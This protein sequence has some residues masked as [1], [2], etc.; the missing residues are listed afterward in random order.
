[1]ENSI[2]QGLYDLFNAYVDILIRSIPNEANAIERGNPTT[3]FA[4]TPRQQLSLLANASTLVLHLFSSVTGS[5]SKGI[6]CAVDET[7]TEQAES[8]QQKG[9]DCWILSIQ[10]AA[11]RLRAYFC[12]QF[13]LKVMSLQDE[14]ILS[15]ETNKNRHSESHSLHPPLPSMAFQVLFLQLRQ[16]EKLAREVFVGRDWEVKDLLREL[17]ESVFFWLSNN[18]FWTIDG[19][20]SVAE[21]SNGFEKFLLDM[22]FIVEIARFG[23]YFSENLMDASLGL[24]ERMEMEFLAAGLNPHSDILYDGWAAKA[25]KAAIDK[26]LQ[27][28][29][30][31]L[32]PVEGPVVTL[33]EYFDEQQH[34]DAVDFVEQ[35]GGRYL[36]GPLGFD[37]KTANGDEA[38]ISKLWETDKV[39]ITTME[40]P[41]GVIGE[42]DC[43]DTAESLS[44][45]SVCFDDPRATNSA[46]AMT[47]IVQGMEETVAPVGTLEEYF[48]KKQHEDLEDFVDE[49]GGRYSEDPVG[50]EYRK[51]ALETEANISL[52]Q[53]ME[54]AEM[55]TM[56][57]PPVVNEEAD[58]DGTAKNLSNN[59]VYFEDSQAAN[60]AYSMTP[61]FQKMK[62]TEVPPSES[63]TGILMEH[64]DKEAAEVCVEEDAPSSCSDYN[65]MSEEEVANAASSVIED[66]AEPES[67]DAGVIELVVGEDSSELGGE[68]SRTN[69]AEMLIGEQ[70]ESEGVDLPAM[71][72]YQFILDEGS[73]K[74]EK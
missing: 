17:M 72:A 5:I 71:E 69:K 3:N 46:S 42:A 34:E 47:P 36:E 48:D 19:E 28:E 22:Q 50:L 31:M 54:K 33:G 38:T 27:I 29:K 68:R 55:T 20:S 2:L 49:E 8:L 12:H 66:N 73:N 16:L 11:D 6:E 1:M 60:L 26:L 35:D 52:Q 24:I 18:E 40:Q 15:P 30:T 32:P 23:G 7:P 70:Q 64:S 44:N 13:V 53:D 63:S 58:C 56:G 59:F 45:S 25:A 51:S 10:E 67:S 41:A 21:Q 14:Q 65:S 9:I 4:N 37:E 62:E 57:K 39:E 74:P 61:I 43:D